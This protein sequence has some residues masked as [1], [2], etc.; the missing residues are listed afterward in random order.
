MNNATLNITA[1][2][3]SDIEAEFKTGVSGG[4][5]AG[6]V[7][8]CIVVVLFAIGYSIGAQ[9]LL[10]KVKSCKCCKSNKTSNLPDESPRQ[11]NDIDRRETGLAGN[12]ADGQ[13]HNPVSNQPNDTGKRNNGPLIDPDLMSATSAPFP[14]QDLNSTGQHLLSQLKH[15]T[16]DYN[17]GSGNDRNIS[18]APGT[19]MPTSPSAQGGLPNIHTDKKGAA[20]GW[21]ALDSD[22]RGQGND[23]ESGKATSKRELTKDHSD[24]KE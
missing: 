7:I 18:S 21:N 17:T 8:A 6:I 4:G 9:N 10:D 12:Q 13:A 20:Q 16:S 5:I 19:G 2:W 23:E 15:G 14:G 11:P 3:V 1:Y 22:R 24:A